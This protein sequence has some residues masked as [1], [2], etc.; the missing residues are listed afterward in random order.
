MNID[1]SQL[2]PNRDSPLRPVIEFI[3]ALG[4][5]AAQIHENV[6]RQPAGHALIMNVLGPVSVLNNQF[7]TDITINA[8]QVTGPLLGW[9]AGCAG[10][11]F[12][13]DWGGEAPLDGLMSGKSN[14]SLLD[15]TKGN[16]MFSNNQIRL[17]EV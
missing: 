6:I 16:I 1:M 8:N 7:R 12:I 4:G 10:V 17:G 11:V 14:L 2:A 5:Y 3:S 15:F 9:I 13:T